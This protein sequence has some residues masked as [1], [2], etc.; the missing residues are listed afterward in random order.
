MSTNSPYRYRYAAVAPRPQ[1]APLLRI[2]AIV[3]AVL[4]ALVVIAVLAY[5]IQL[6][7]APRPVAQPTAAAQAVQ[8][9][10][11][12]PAAVAQPADTIEGMPLDAFWARYQTPTAWHVVAHTD[13]GW[14]YFCD[15]ARNGGTYWRKC[16]ASGHCDDTLCAFPTQA[17][18]DDFYNRLLGE[19]H[20][21]GAAILNPI[22][23]T[24]PPLPMGTKSGWN[25]QRALPP[26]EVK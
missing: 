2:L 22:G 24:P 12:S 15:G 13:D 10:A 11:L 20:I 19:Y 1:P 4:T 16:G 5:G 8:P 23:Y 18:V 7:R 14:V 6:A 21:S 9:A 3:G 25:G 26:G 17:A